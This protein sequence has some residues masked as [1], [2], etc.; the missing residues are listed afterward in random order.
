MAG[1]VIVKMFEAMKIMLGKFIKEP[2]LAEN[3]NF[4]NNLSTQ[5]TWLAGL[6]F[7]QISQ[8]DEFR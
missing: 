8:T 3:L 4:L 7:I 1:E 2:A 6:S 5:T